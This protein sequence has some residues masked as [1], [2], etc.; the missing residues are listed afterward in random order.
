MYRLKEHFCFCMNDERRITTEVRY[1]SLM[2][3]GKRVSP[4]SQKW[5]I[6]ASLLRLEPIL[7]GFGEVGGGDTGCPF[8]VGDGVGEFFLAHYL[9]IVRKKFTDRTIGIPSHSPFG[10]GICHTTHFLYERYRKILE[11]TNRGTML[12]KT[13]HT[14]NSAPRASTTKTTVRKAVKQ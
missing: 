12:K 10:V 13:S 11:S 14:K 3:S 5:K 9:L 7:H 2:Y 1:H 4:N 8:E 6:R